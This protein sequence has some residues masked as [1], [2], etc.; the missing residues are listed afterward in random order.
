MKKLASMI[1]VILLAVLAIVPATGLADSGYSESFGVSEGILVNVQKQ[2]LTISVKDSA[3][4]TSK[5]GASVKLYRLEPVFQF[6][7]SITRCSDTNESK[8]E[9]IGFSSGTSTSIAKDSSS[10]KNYGYSIGYSESISSGSSIG[11][12]VSSGTSTGI[13]GTGLNVGY[14][15]SSVDGSHAIGSADAVT[16]KYFHVKTLKTDSKGKASIKVEPG[17]YKVVVTDTDYSKVTKE[18][19]VKE[20]KA[21]TVAVSIAPKYGTLNMTLKDLKTEK[22]TVVSLKLLNSKGKVIKTFKTNSSGKYTLKLE[23]GNYKIVTADKKYKE[24]TKF[25]FKVKAGATATVLGKVTPIYPLTIKVQDKKGNT[26]KG[27]DVKVYITNK[28]FEKVTKSVSSKGTVSFDN[29]PDGNYTVVAYRKEKG[30]NVTLYTGTL[31][32]N[33][34]KPGDKCTKTIKLN[35]EIK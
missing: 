26:V 13:S 5:S 10:G 22:G 8:G 15:E 30:K 4:G 1:L 32:I 2:T 35:K 31:Y 3:R 7:D 28:N 11:I 25:S 23:P 20:G 9:S 14:S 16:W 21:K 27:K 6:S 34:S 18:F 17:D 19:T 33:A 12:S 29:V 24:E